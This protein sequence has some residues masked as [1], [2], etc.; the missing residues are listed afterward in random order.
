MDK[1]FTIYDPLLGWTNLD[2][3]DIFLLCPHGHDGQDLSSPC[4]PYLVHVV[5]ERLLTPQMPVSR[6]EPSPCQLARTSAAFS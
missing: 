1:T 5:I 4:P 6:I 2:I 3:F